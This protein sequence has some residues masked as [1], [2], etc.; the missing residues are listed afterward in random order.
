[1]DP[2]RVGIIGFGYWGPN[3]ARNFYELP[4]SN[5]VAVADLS[6]D[7]L[8][9][10]RLRYPQLIVKQDYRELYSL[11]LDAVVVATPPAGHYP[12][13]KDCL[14]HNL[15]VLVEKPLTLKSEQAEEVIRLAD[16]R[17]LTLMVGHTFEYNS[18]VHALKK[19][20]D[21]GFLGQVY[22]LD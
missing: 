4:G 10:A 13:A 16:E 9:Q 11:G 7:R 14:E 5:L 21:E 2:I 17:T 18:A 12:I 8:K 15:N 19:Y 1:M 3:L 22:Y 20:V 6:E